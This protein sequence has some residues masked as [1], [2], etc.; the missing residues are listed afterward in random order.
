MRWQTVEVVFR[1]QR[2]YQKG[3]NYS[4]ILVFLLA[5][6]LRCTSAAEAHTHVPKPSQENNS[7][8]TN[9]KKDCVVLRRAF[10]HGSGKATKTTNNVHALVFGGGGSAEGGGVVT[11]KPG[12][13]LL[14]GIILN[15][16]WFHALRLG[17]RSNV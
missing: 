6:V 12:H 13:A 3:A 7:E 5:L 14:P 15:N 4:S 2:D 8:N 17:S 16:K 1:K 11:H 9:P 10:N